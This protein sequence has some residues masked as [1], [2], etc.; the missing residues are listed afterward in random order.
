[1][2][3]P[4]PP[5]FIPRLVCYRAMATDAAATTGPMRGGPHCG[6]VTIA[7]GDR[8]QSDRERVERLR[9][10]AGY[11]LGCTAP[12]GELPAL[13]AQLGL[14]P[15][16]S[17]DVKLRTAFKHALAKV[18]SQHRRGSRAR[19]RAGFASDGGSS[20]CDSASGQSC[21]S[22]GK[23][24]RGESPAMAKATV[25]ARPRGRRW[26]SE[27]TSKAIAGDAA[28]GKADAEALRSPS[29]AGDE[30]E[31]LVAQPKVRQQDT[32]SK[33]RS[34][35]YNAHGAVRRCSG[36]RAMSWT[37]RKF[38]RLPGCSP[39]RCQRGIRCATNT[40]DAG[41][42]STDV[43]ASEIR[44]QA[45][46]QCRPDV[47]GLGPGPSPAPPVRRWQS[48]SSPSST[49][50]SAAAQ[51][52]APS[53]SVVGR[54]GSPPHVATQPTPSPR[55]ARGAGSKPAASL[56][57]VA[58][59]SATLRKRQNV[60]TVAEDRMQLV[61]PVSK[62]HGCRQDL[63]TMRPR[64][65]GTVPTMTQEN[66]GFAATSPSVS[67]SAAANPSAGA[68]TLGRNRPGRGGTTQSAA[69]SAADTWPRPTAEAIAAASPRPV[70]SLDSSAA[71]ELDSATLQLERLVEE[72]HLAL[73]RDGLLSPSLAAAWNLPRERGLLA[74]APDAAIPSLDAVDR[75]LEELQRGLA[76]IDSALGRST[77]PA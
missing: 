62:R 17:K 18:H 72:T 2:V 63:S 71:F 67:W 50:L 51:T 45:V 34:P 41:C 55:L 54:T 68:S 5:P 37:P 32:G 4:A 49:L 58:S 23:S 11:P 22:D 69:A 36:S 19:A 28:S 7:T 73:V 42:V 52:C 14:F 9:A 24:A 20:D 60:A 53:S 46:S 21:H 39:A 1:M 3:L 56:E 33:G 66:R 74:T 64:R 75:A 40:N 12:E 27:S 57:R 25:A 76:E 44:A 35:W 47:A 31:S 38:R 30:F 13:L 6:G 26:Q 61:S 59:A 16:G 10:A 15:G 8:F 29:V 70:A 48:S 43:G 77:V 65:P